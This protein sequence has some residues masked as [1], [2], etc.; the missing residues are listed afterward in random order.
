MADVA[1]ALELKSR[2]E[3]SGYGDL[4][5]VSPVHHDSKGGQVRAVH[6]RLSPSGADVELGLGQLEIE[7][8]ALR[9]TNDEWVKALFGLDNPSRAAKTA[10]SAPGRS[11]THDLAHVRRG[12]GRVGSHVRDPNTR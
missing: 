12:T 11:A 7:H 3:L 8:S 10:S 1:G 2:A 9:L 4:T 6:R 5:G